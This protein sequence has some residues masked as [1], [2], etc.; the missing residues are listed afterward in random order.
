MI[1]ALGGAVLTGCGQEQ[2][3]SM[4]DPAGP[5][6]S[7]TAGLWWLMLLMSL[8]V[9]LIVMGLL[10]FA[11]F[12]RR[13]E[14]EGADRPEDATP[15]LGHVPFVLLG[16]AIIPAGV[17]VTLLVFAL[18]T[19]VSMQRP[20]AT[21]TIEVVGYQ[22]WWETR[23]PEQDITT[24]NEIY[25]PAGEPVRLDLRAADV[26]HSFWVPRLGGKRDLLPEE[27]NTFVIEADE[28]GVYR[29]QCAEY[30][31]LQHAKMAF[32][33]VALPRDE[34]EAWLKD[35]QAP[36]PEPTSALSERGRE[37]FSEAA[38]AACHRIEGVAEAT[39]QIGPDLTHIGSR[40]T[41]GAGTVENNRGNLYGWIMDPQRIKPGN[42]M[43][44]T[45]IEPDDLHAL[46][47]YLESLD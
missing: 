19:Q 26:I 21:L 5:D 38:C 36:P 1:A 11:V 28:P 34:F 3:Q 10:A 7:E 9:Y 25:I 20:P 29:G 4:L 47:T 16:G 13:K 6:A 27:E 24:A 40:R 23:Y 37:V 43:P 42:R 41:L 31:G 39:G 8:V 35:K 45:R 14:V 22:W 15:P 44:P 32:H 18:E 17:L 46:V 2:V 30:C 12:R 33:V